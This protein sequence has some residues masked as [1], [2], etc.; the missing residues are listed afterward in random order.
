MENFKQTE[1]VAMSSPLAPLANIFMYHYE[2]IWLQDCPTSFKPC[3]Y[4]RYLDD[5][6]LLFRS[7]EHI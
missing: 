2:K 5:T 6:L 3:K 7:S 1:G 4:F